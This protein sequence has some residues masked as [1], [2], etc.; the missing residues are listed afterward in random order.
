MAMSQEIMPCLGEISLRPRDQKLSLEKIPETGNGVPQFY[1][2]E[3]HNSA[4]VCRKDTHSSSPKDLTTVDT[5][6]KNKKQKISKNPKKVERYLFFIYR[7]YINLTFPI[8][9]KMYY[10]APKNNDN[11]Y[12]HH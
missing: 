9:T 3:G 2:G 4:R 5:I 12:E 8:L 11:K 6:C 10:H 7:W 1:D